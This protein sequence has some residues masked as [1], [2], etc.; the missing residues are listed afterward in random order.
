MTKEAVTERYRKTLV[1][2][3]KH[4]GM[5]AWK[6]KDYRHPIAL[7]AI[8]AGHLERRDGRFLF[9]RFKDG[10]LAFTPEG[11]DFAEGA[12]QA[13]CTHE[14]EHSFGYGLARCSST[15]C[16][17]CNF[18]PAEAAAREAIA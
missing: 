5:S 7:E 16:V 9:E 12:I 3:Y 15:W 14:W 18:V 2:L 10:H 6:P 17:K 1:A 8:A 11:R 13:G 4:Y